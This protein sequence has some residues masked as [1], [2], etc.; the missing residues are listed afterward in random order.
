MSVIPLFV[1]FLCMAVR[2]A[3]SHC[4]GKIPSF[5]DLLYN[6]DSGWLNSLDNSLR[7]YGC[8]FSGPGDLPGPKLFNLFNTTSSETC[9]VC[10]LSPVKILFLTYEL[11]IRL[12]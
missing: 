6:I 10:K 8:Q 2:R 11:N 3:S 5:I 7:R 9:S 1:P 12:Q 4:D